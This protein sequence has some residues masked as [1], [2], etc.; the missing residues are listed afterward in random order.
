VSPARAIAAVLVLAAG[1]LGGCASSWNPLV[2]VGIMSEPARKPKELTPI[3]ATVTPRAAWTAQ[4][5]KAA[6]F[7]FRP[8][9]EGGRVYAAS[10]E[11]P[12]SVVEEETGRVVSRIDTKKKLSSG[13]EVGEDRVI[14]GTSKGEVVALDA[15]GGTV[16]TTAVGGEVIAPVSVSRKVAVVRTADGRIYG[17]STE[18]GKR[19]WVFQRPMPS[20]LLRS[21]AGVKAMGADVLAGYPNGK[22]IAL[23]IEDGSLTWEVTVSQPRG[24]TDLERIADVAGLPVIDGNNVCA[25]AFQG[26]VACFEIQSR[27]QLWSRE[28][29]TALALSADTRYVYVV[30]DSGA[31]H[32]LDKG[33]GASVWKQDRL[34]YR[35]LTAPMLVAGLVVVGDG[36]G[37]LH[38]LSTEDGSIVGRLATDGSAVL[39]MVP[40]SGGAL[41]QTAKGSLSLV[42]F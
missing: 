17:L 11:G 28:L 31:V 2:W 34:Q 41:V 25:A 8:D 26:K 39:S 20:L 35:K 42:R 4:V 3:T 40:V 10:E 6:G 33:S 32:A 13:V 21:E 29:S 7:G 9:I 24:A 19:R 18:D 15:A 30:D 38:A 22:M 14:V 12:V 37:Y 1:A 23:D 16:W 27:N 5:G 36:F